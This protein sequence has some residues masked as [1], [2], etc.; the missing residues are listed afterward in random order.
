MTGTDMAII[1][2]G[3]T[4][5]LA[6]VLGVVQR[7]VGPR[8]DALKERVVKL[9][10]ANEKL[11]D[12]LSRTIESGGAARASLVTELTAKI[13][14]GHDRINPLEALPDKVDGLARKC[15]RIPD[16]AASVARIEGKM[17]G[18]FGAGNK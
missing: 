12:R 10:E 5:A 2:G 8:L 17:S 9:E 4:T 3:G 15:E 13:T 7:Y 16:L 18:N 14:H 1:G 6:F 11:E